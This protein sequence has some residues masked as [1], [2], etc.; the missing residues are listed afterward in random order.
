MSNFIATILHSD[1]FII[2]FTIIALLETFLIIAI[3]FY[4]GKASF[5]KKMDLY[6]IGQA[7]DYGFI[8]NSNRAFSYGM[9]I[10]FPQTFGKRVHKN[11]D[12]SKIQAKDKW[13]YIL[14]VLII[15]FTIP[16]FIIAS[17]I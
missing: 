16:I 2:I 9:S 5:I 12:I 15:F 8:L 3:R 17:V 1:I 10:L 7:V 6:F 4:I 14:H 13:P 11:V